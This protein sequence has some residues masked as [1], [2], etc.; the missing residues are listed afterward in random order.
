MIMKAKHSDEEILA[1]VL[2]NKLYGYLVVDIS[3]PDHLIE[4]LKNF[5]PLIKRLE[6]TNEYLSDYMAKRYAEKNPKCPQLKRETVVQCFHAKE[7]LLMT[8]L[9]RFYL[10]KGLK[11]TKIHR[12]IQ[13]QP[14]KALAPFVDHVSSMRIEA[15]LAGNR[16]TANSAKL[17]GNAG[18]GKVRH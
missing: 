2:E 8:P 11:V 16:T 17:F 5:P 15:E 1:S 14:F 9:L 7:H 4:N 3:T 13:Y 12:V 6:V 10:Q 18:Y